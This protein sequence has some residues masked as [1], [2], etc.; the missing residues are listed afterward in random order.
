[1][2]KQPG[3]PIFGGLGFRECVVYPQRLV[4]CG[5]LMGSRKCFLEADVEV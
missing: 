2:D 4:V 5:S 1:M 3:R